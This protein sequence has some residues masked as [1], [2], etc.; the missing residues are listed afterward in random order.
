MFFK[1][2]LVFCFFCSHY[3]RL[4]QVH[5]L[6]SLARITITFIYMEMQNH[7]NNRAWLHFLFTYHFL[8]EREKLFG[9]CWERTPAA[10][11]TGDHVIRYSMPLGLVGQITSDVHEDDLGQV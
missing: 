7:T 3:S 6:D 5:L 2:V 8:P 9:C 10:C 11:V 1:N 4:H